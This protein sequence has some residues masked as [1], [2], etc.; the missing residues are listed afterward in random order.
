MNKK[1][2]TDS[3][4]KR[5]EEICREQYNLWRVRRIDK[6]YIKAM[7]AFADERVAQLRKDAK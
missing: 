6:P 1:A 5:A 3:L 2:S 4:E 7:L